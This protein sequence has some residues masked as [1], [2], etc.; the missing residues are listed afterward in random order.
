M[1]STG[2][3]ENIGWQVGIKPKDL[4]AIDFRV[5]R[6]GYNASDYFIEAI[7]KTGKKFTTRNSALVGS[8]WGHGMF[9]HRACEFC[10]DIA[11]E[12]ADVT[13]GDAWLP[14][15]S[16]DYLGTNIIVS[17]SD[18]FE[19]YLKKYENEI[20]IEEVSVDD[21]YETQ[22]GNYRHRRDGMKVRIENASY[23]V[24]TKRTLSNEKV[25]PKRNALYL[26]RQYLSEKSITFFNIA[27]KTNS[28]QLF[29]VLMWPLLLKYDYLNLG[30]R[31]TVKQRLKKMV[32]NILRV[33]KV[34]RFTH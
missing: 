2:F 14:K 4:Q 17:R 19:K 6:D 13:F 10:D 12:L 33:L 32:I 28:I 34:K 7:S 29:K 27:K 26:Y 9:K 8:N 24:P 25:S 20:F 1:K 5:K 16:N 18:V 21:F 11:G 30:L 31:L 15:Y 23:W 3:A 22:A